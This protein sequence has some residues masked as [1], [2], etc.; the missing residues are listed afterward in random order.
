LTHYDPLLLADASQALAARLRAGVA[1]EREAEREALVRLYERSSLERLERDGAVLARLSPPTPAGSLYGQQK[2]S[3]MRARDGATTTTTATTP[4][5][6]PPH[7]RFRAGD[8]VLLS[9][10]MRAA[11]ATAPATSAFDAT[12]LEVTR[13][14]VVLALDNAAGD[15]LAGVVAAAASTSPPVVLWRLDRSPTDAAAQRQL[16]AIARLESVAWAP[17]S[18]SDVD[19]FEALLRACLVGAPEAVVAG[20]GAPSAPSPL[21]RAASTPP[22]WVRDAAWRARAVALLGELPGLNDSQ[23][24]AVAT[25]LTRTLTLW[26]GPPGTGKT[27]TCLALVEVL[28]RASEGEK[29]ATPTAAALPVL[30]VADTNAAADNLV[31]GLAAR[32]LRVVRAGGAARVRPSLRHL[33]LEAQAEQTPLGE[34]AAEGRAR[35]RAL[36]AQARYLKQRQWEREGEGAEGDDE[37]GGGDD[38]AS[39]SSSSPQLLEAEARREWGKAERLARSAMRSV[40]EHAQVV[41]ATCNASGDATLLALGGGGGGKGGGGRRSTTTT[42]SRPIT[43]RAV[44]ID[45]ATQATEPATLVPLVRGAQMAVLAGD[46]RQLPP[47]VVSRAALLPPALLGRTLFDRLSSSAAEDEQQQNSTGDQL[48][49]QPRLL[50]RQY[51]MHPALARFPSRR[52]YQGLLKDGVKASERPPPQGV[53]WPSAS[54]PAAVVCVEGG[55]GERR[56]DDD[57]RDDEEDDESS[58]QRRGRSSGGGSYCNAA[59]AEQCLRALRALLSGGDVR[60]VAILSPYRGQVRLIERLLRAPGPAA[61]LERVQRRLE[62]QEED[63]AEQDAAGRASAS[64]RRRNGLEAP[65]SATPLVT[66]S[67]VDGFQGREA[68]AVILSVVRSNRRAQIGFV[69]DPRRLC[70]AASRARRALVVVCSERTLRASGSADWRAFL[71]W[72]EEEGVV[73]RRGDAAEPP[74]PW[75]MDGEV[76]WSMAAA[77]GK[78]RTS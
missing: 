12:V 6:L 44:V 52:F 48:L 24:A 35:S 21:E 28:V 72:A 22:P 17:S 66:V 64:R 61:W 4:P 76:R 63:A 29:T 60:S 20:P 25:A 78:R 5:P 57:D 65:F 1:A 58:G 73:V 49:L 71:D 74:P 19:A 10:M 53:E 62:E 68:D 70:V 59:E 9:P 15:A 31:E 55:E 3:V 32:G 46:P 45:E 50:N 8:P 47:T 40:L 37:D 2:W 36:F 42:T 30:A 43:F 69:A 67:S 11:A 38:K 14:R 13:D 7:H 18:H 16:D 41:A 33:S 23:R 39:S 26:Q 51:R 75:P 34:R 56:D 27:R 54:T 77:A